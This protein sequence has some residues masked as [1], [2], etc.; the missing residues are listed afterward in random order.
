MLA[1]THSAYAPQAMAVTVDGLATSA[2]LDVLRKGGS[3]ADAAIAANAVLTVVLP[4][5]CGVGGD[6][7]VLVHQPGEPPQLL[8]AAGRAGSGADAEELRARGLAKVPPDEIASVTVPGCVDG[9]VAL[10]EHYGRLPLADLLAP[11][12]EYAQKG[13]P[14]SPF[15]AHTLSGQATLG[16][17]I[18]GAGGQVV[19]GQRLRRPQYARILND[20]AGGGRD[21]FYLGTFG[22]ALQNIGPDLFSDNDL[23]SSQAMWTAPLSIDAFGGRIWTTQ[24]PARLSNIGFGLDRRSSR[25]P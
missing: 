23:Q 6:L 13:F 14:A 1:P 2:A 11:A 17:H 4:S 25:S 15:V 22:R 5:Q 18:D 20:I 8:E 16:E 12:I 7:F 21:A 9:W 19:P 10:H 3:A 24:P